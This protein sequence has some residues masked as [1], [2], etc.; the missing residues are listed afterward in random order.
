MYSFLLGITLSR[1]NFRNNCYYNN[2][3]FLKYQIF[4]FL[5]NICFMHLIMFD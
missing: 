3:F 2:I 4:F 5:Y 1:H